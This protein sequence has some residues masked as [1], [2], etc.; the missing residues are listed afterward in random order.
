MSFNAM[1]VYRGDNFSKFT[2][3][4]PVNGEVRTVQQPFLFDHVIPTT[5]TILIS[6]QR[7]VYIPPQLT[8]EKPVIL[9]DYAHPLPLPS[10]AD[11]SNPSN[12]TNVLLQ[13]LIDIENKKLAVEEKIE[14]NTEFKESVHHT[15]IKHDHTIDLKEH[16]EALENV[17][18]KLSKLTEKKDNVDTLPTIRED[19]PKIPKRYATI[20]KKREEARMK[21][22]AAL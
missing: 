15:D 22:R 3:K 12:L 13:R 20:K 16:R 5:S 6:P 7:K 18:S 4:P 8:F 9:N 1:N 2:L 10:H 21:S 14:H 11:T 19:S 17:Q